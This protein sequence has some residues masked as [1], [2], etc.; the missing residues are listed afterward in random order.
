MMTKIWPA[1]RA[2]A[3]LLAVVA[4][5]N[6]A[7]HAKPLPAAASPI[8]ELTTDQK[9]AIEALDV[10]LA[11]YDALV[12]KIGDPDYRTST[13]KLV[14]GLK[15][16]RDALRRNFDSG[17][18]NDLKLDLFQEYQRTAIWLMP[19]NTPPRSR[20]DG[21]GAGRAAALASPK[22]QEIAL[23][24]LEWQIAALESR[25]SRQPEDH[26]ERVALKSIREHHTALRAKFTKA[27]YDALLAE[28][29][30]FG[31]K[32]RAQQASAPAAK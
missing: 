27:G 4:P 15:G 17:A 22:G 11:A 23:V 29:S 14:D 8:V 18:Y 32:R 26:P 24:T 12:A 6:S 2:L 7:D 9:A 28:I 10:M 19:P 31:Q 25:T 13:A 5:L 3:V 1:V 16:R 21:E 30:A 20:V